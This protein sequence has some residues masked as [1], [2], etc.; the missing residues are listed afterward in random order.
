[1]YNEE[2]KQR[3]IES[4]IKTESRKKIANECFT[5][6]QKY[7]EQ[8]DADICTFS[9][10]DLNLVLSQIIGVRRSSEATRMTVLKLY[11]KW[12]MS[13]NYPN[14]SDAILH[15]V[16]DTTERFA[17]QYV[18]GPQH[19][20]SILNAAFGSD[21]SDSVDCI[22]KGFFW[23]GFIGV[24]EDV[25]TNVSIYDV[26]LSNHVIAHNNGV[27]T[28]EYP[29]CNEAF[30]VIKK[31]AEMNSFEVIHPLYPDKRSFRPRY[32]STQL[33]RGLSK[34]KS[35]RDL[36]RLS[37]DK[38]K[39]CEH[40][41]LKKYRISYNRVYISG[42]FYRTWCAE[43]ETADIPERYRIPVDFGDFIRELPGSE[44]I[45]RR[46][47]S[48]KKKNMKDDYEKWKQIYGFYLSPR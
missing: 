8:L 46:Y 10:D 37:F 5:A 11:T 24:P 22:Y 36:K 2:M 1:M 27:T 28:D 33:L 45:S 3:F 25:V 41:L 42:V 16:P 44:G 23:L 19:L 40:P 30:P 29:I 47:F 14:V 4:E 12:C 15:A 48:M 6:T 34:D 17:T 9:L 26:D 18:S 43:K 21:E 7:E 38:M 32:N 20:K 13:I 35:L 39:E 31:L